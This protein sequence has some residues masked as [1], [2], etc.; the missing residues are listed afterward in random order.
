MVFENNWLV[1][2]WYFIVLSFYAYFL[3]K[4]VDVSLFHEITTSLSKDEL[5]SVCVVGEGV[6]KK[7]IPRQ[8]V[9]LNPIPTSLFLI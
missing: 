3:Y 5:K 7:T 8:N 2:V 1:L 4:I 6:N 9:V